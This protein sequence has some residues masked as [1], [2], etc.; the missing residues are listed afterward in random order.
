MREIGVGDLKWQPW[1]QAWVPISTSRQK[2]HLGDEERRKEKKG[3]TR[4][5]SS[6]EMGD[7]GIEKDV[8]S[9]ERSCLVG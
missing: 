3:G 9:S 1:Q 2:A 7:E 4:S 8:D 6:M 5:D